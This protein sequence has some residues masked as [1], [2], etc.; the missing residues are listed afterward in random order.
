MT[1]VKSEGKTGFLKE[2]LFDDPEA[3]KTQ[4]EKAWRKAGNKG[5]ISESLI[6]KVR[7]ELGLAGKRSAKAKS[8]VE[9][10][11]RTPA[12]AKSSG[13]KSGLKVGVR[14]N[15]KE[16]VTNSKMAAERSSGMRASG[17]G[18]TRALIRL[19]DGID[20][21]LHEARAAGGIPDFEEALRK[22][23]RILVRSHKD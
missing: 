8:T 1:M 4:V 5:T 14:G 15:A 23:R 21:L 11:K 9:S 2:F 16:N 6:Y 12:P 10:G 20:D 17:G 13:G 7:A 3:S 22:A 19:E 18:L